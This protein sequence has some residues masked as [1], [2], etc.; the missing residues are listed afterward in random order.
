MPFNAVLSKPPRKLQHRRPTYRDLANVMAAPKAIGARIGEIS[1]TATAYPSNSLRVRASLI[2]RRN[3]GQALPSRST[4][5][6][7]RKHCNTAGR[8]ASRLGPKSLST[9]AARHRKR[10]GYS[11]RAAPG[12]ARNAAVAPQLNRTVSTNVIS[13]LV[14]AGASKSYSQY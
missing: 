7:K 1:M 11:T 4:A 9:R 12:I 8:R 13:A 6:K 10:D 2:D 3:A 5:T 14:K